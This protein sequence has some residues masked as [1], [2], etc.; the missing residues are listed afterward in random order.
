MVKKTITYTDFNGEEVTSD[1]Y[2][3]L[4]KAELVEIELGHK[5]GLGE[6]IQRIIDSKD[7]AAIVAEF[8]K[9]LLMAYGQKSLDGT[10]F[11]KNDALREEFESSAAYSEIFME[12][13]TD[14]EKAAA[15]IQGVIPE[16]MTEETMKSVA[17]LNNDSEKFN[18]DITDKPETTPRVITDKDII[19]FST[20]EL[21]IM[22]SKLA[23]GEWV[24]G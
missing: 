1:L 8:K 4:T 23:S 10:R 24:R 3:N 11:I 21:A 16:D 12:L 5:D 14:A 18:D 17:K 6:S 15:F 13:V 22:N 9:I 19:G 7:G 20:D 2:F